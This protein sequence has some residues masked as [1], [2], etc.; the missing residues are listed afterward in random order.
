LLSIS[1]NLFVIT[2]NTFKEQISASKLRTPRFGDVD[3]RKLE[4]AGT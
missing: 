4:G 1:Y 3:W 2:K